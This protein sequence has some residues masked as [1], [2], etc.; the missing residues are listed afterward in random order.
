MSCSDASELV[1]LEEDVR[2]T[3][4]R[5]SRIGLKYLKL[6]RNHCWAT[7]KPAGCWFRSMATNQLSAYLTTSRHFWT[8][9]SWLDDVSTSFVEHESVADGRQSLRRGL[10]M[11]FGVPALVKIRYP[12]Q[13]L[14]RCL[15]PNNWRTES[16]CGAPVAEILGH[17]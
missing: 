13:I 4:D 9:K 7:T 16:C 14:E 1:D 8:R 6:R 12:L 17:L 5:P 3:Q 10:K 15:A 11:D 2:M